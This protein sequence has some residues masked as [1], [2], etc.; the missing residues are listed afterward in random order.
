ML[1]RLPALRSAIQQQIYAGARTQFTY[2]RKSYVFYVVAMARD[3][4]NCIHTVFACA[5][6]SLVYLMAGV[7]NCDTRSCIAPIVLSA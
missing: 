7:P 6:A 5:P 3:I 1:E 4:A 2:S